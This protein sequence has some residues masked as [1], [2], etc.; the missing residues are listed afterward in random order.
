MSLP[1][2]MAIGK[3]LLPPPCQ[4]AQCPVPA[5]PLSPPG[6]PGWGSAQRLCRPSPTA[7]CWPGLWLGTR[8]YLWPPPWLPVPWLSSERGDT[9]QSRHVGAGWHWDRMTGTLY[10]C[11]AQEAL[12]VRLHL[13]HQQCQTHENP[14][15]LPPKFLVRHSREMRAASCGAT[16]GPALAAPRLRYRTKPVGH[17]S[18]CDSP[19]L[20]Q[21]ILGPHMQAP[22]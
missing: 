14:S 20:V 7:V 12:D 4:H 15:A 13:R 18:T 16:L 11:R 6:A 22:Q 3:A 5:R 17:V 2:R 10:I 1:P 21:N 8:C 19:W 9:T